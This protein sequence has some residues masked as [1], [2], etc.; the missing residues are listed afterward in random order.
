MLDGPVEELADKNDMFGEPLRLARC[1]ACGVVF[2]PEVPL[3]ERLVEWYDYMAHQP[4]PF[5]SGVWLG[6]CARSSRSARRGAC[7]K[8]G[9]VAVSS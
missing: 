6:P 1:E 7:S 2:Q 8:S 9:L 5:S 3:P 4:P